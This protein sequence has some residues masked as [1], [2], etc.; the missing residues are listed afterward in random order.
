M[1]KMAAGAL[2][3]LS[4]RQKILQLCGSVWPG[5]RKRRAQHAEPNAILASRVGGENL[6]LG[7][8]VVA[9]DHDHI[10][11]FELWRLVTCRIAME[12]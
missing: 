1:Y 9:L 7:H 6:Q 4:K 10:A 11:E 3:D 2:L 12:R 5:R 8:F